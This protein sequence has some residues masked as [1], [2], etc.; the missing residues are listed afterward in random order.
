MAKLAHAC[1]ACSITL[2]GILLIAPILFYTQVFAPCWDCFDFEAGATH[3]IGHLLGLHH[4][5]QAQPINLNLQLASTASGGA[6]AYANYSCLAQWASVVTADPTA[7]LLPT[8]MQSF[9]Q[10]P[11]EAC[12]EQDDLD[13][14]NTLYP[15]CDNLVKVRLRR[16]AMAFDGRPRPA[17]AFGDLP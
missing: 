14:L 10:T 9:T 12:I 5:D 11:P 3:E 16:P 1:S 8:V 15:A 2:R 13:A 17:T 6:G 4:P 7:P